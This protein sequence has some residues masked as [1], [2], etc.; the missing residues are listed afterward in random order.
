MRDTF[1]LARLTKTKPKFKTGSEVLF[2]PSLDE[3]DTGLEG[4]LIIDGSYY[5]DSTEL[6]SFLPF[7][8]TWVYLF[9]G[10]Q[11]TAIEKDLK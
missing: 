4:K 3:L 9:K 7:E 5:K 10:I 6:D 8:P 1:K 2:L 11:L